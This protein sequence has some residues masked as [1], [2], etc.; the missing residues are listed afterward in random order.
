MT[1]KINPDKTK[2]FLK[3]IKDLLYSRK[4]A[5]PK[6]DSVIGTLASLFQEMPY[7]KFNHRNLEKEKITLLRLKMENF[8][9]K[10]GKLNSGATNELHWWLKNI[11]LANRSIELPEVNFAITTDVS[12]EY[13]VLLRDPHSQRSRW[14]NVQIYHKSYLELKAIFYVLK[15]YSDNWKGHKYTRTRSDNT[16]D[17]AYINSIGGSVSGSCDISGKPIWGLCIHE[18]VW[19]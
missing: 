11:P 13:R 8:N 18:Q 10:P 15:S 5:I 4:T 9:A 2:V 12:E 6:L 1:V 14:N 3:K 16:M 7:G 19:I 17:I